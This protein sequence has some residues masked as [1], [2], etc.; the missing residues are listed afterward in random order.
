MKALILA[1]GMG[2]RLRT[3][4]SDVP[5]PLAPINGK[6]FIQCLLDSLLPYNFDEIIISTCY[7]ADKIVAVCGEFHEDVPITYVKETTP[8]GT[9]GAI[10]LAISR[11]S[12]DNCEYICVLNGDTFLELD[13]KKML[14]FANEHAAEV[15]IAT[16]FVDN[17][18]RYGA[19]SMDQEVIKGFNAAGRDESGYINGGVYLLKPSALSEFIIGRPFSF[20]K[21]FLEKYCINHQLYA[22]RTD[23]Y[24]I[25][26]GVPDDYNRAQREVRAHV[27]K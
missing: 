6:P 16:K 15:T 22:Y 11:T 27:Y 19:L 14:A 12:H 23:G 1:G 17:C 26:I 4:V 24:F 18:Y 7:M 2:T 10:R 3:V 20:E 8:L 5:K 13:Y 9:G 21:D 25:D